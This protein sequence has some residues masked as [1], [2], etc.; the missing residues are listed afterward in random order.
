MVE[1]HLDPKKALEESRKLRAAPQQDDTNL[2]LL[3]NGQYGSSIKLFADHVRVTE[4]DQKVREFPI[5]NIVAFQYLKHYTPIALTT[6]VENGENRQVSVGASPIKRLEFD[7]IEKRI[8]QMMIAS[9]CTFHVKRGRFTTTKGFQ[10]RSRERIMTIGN[11][12]SSIML[13]Q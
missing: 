6:Y 3:A 13:T 9:E 1:F 11:A 8:K 5:K 12:T 2:I 7:V 10:R 4:G